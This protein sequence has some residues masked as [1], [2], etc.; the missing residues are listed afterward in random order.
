MERDWLKLMA[1]I[2]VQALASFSANSGECI[3]ICPPCENLHT[4][5]MW[6]TVVAIRYSLLAFADD[7]APRSAHRGELNGK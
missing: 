4:A 6:H 5:T 7:S 1:V 3:V 2:V